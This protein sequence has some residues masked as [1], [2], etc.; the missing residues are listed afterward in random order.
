MTTL[1][2][3]MDSVIGALLLTADESGLT[4]IWFDKGGESHEPHREWQR[5]ESAAGSEPA[6]TIDAARSQL[7]EYFA[8]TRTRFA[9]PLAP[10]GT[11]FQ[12]RVWAAL[13]EIPFGR[14]ISYLELA[15][16]VGD[17]RAV[18]A[19]GGANGKNPLPIVL[20]C[21]RVIGANGSLT[22]FGGGIER[23]RWLLEHERAIPT[24]ATLSLGL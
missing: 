12:Q 4:R 14:T 24:A 1:Y 16:I 10:R 20:P 22:G 17:A 23:K 8:G 15:H 11:P 3:V 9:L 5:A 18:R 19:V 21:H 6:R 2:S 7:D 13:A